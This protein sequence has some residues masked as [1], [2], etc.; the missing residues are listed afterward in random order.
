MFEPK[1]EDP[2]PVDDCLLKPVELEPRP[3]FV[4]DPNGDPDELEELEEEPKR[5]NWFTPLER[6]G[7][8]EPDWGPKGELGWL[9]NRGKRP[10]LLGMHDKLRC[11]SCSLM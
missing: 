10:P 6:L 3:I 1:L 4:F 5:L 2:S 7:L 9:P 11:L 8:E